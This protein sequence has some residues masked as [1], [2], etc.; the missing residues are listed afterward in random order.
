MSSEP[1]VVVLYAPDCPATADAVR[2]AQEALRRV[3]M[4]PEKLIVR[5]I[6]TEEE[7]ALAGMHGSPTVTVAGKDVDAR[8]RE[9]PASLYG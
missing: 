6:E 3:G 2:E 1:E 8:M 7:A 4:P 9:A 5:L